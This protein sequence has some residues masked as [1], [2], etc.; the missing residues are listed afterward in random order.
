MW[1]WSCGG[2]GGSEGSVA[3]DIV[4]LLGETHRVLVEGS[5]H[6]KSILYAAF[7]GYQR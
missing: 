5:R 2:R 4:S 6:A 1:G 7:I 3:R